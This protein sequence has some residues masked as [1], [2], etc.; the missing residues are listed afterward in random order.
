METYILVDIFLEAFEK[1]LHTSMAM[2]VL[3]ARDVKENNTSKKIQNGFGVIGMISLL[4][5]E[6]GSGFLT[7]GERYSSTL[8]RF[9]PSCSLELGF[10]GFLMRND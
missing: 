1:S 10:E 8:V 5:R 3:S 6:A 4:F 9:I 7:N 2:S